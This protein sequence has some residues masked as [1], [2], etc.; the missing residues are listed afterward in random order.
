MDTKNTPVINLDGREDIGPETSSNEV[1]V[2]SDSAKRLAEG[3]AIT[4]K[5]NEIFASSWKS[6]EANA[7]KLLRCQGCMRKFKNKMLIGKHWKA[8]NGKC[9]KD[10]GFELVSDIEIRPDDV[11]TPEEREKADFLLKANK[12]A[13]EAA[14]QANAIRNVNIDRSIKAEDLM[15][16]PMIT[17]DRI[18][19]NAPTDELKRFVQMR[20]DRMTSSRL[21]YADKELERRGVK[22]VASS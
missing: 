9:N 8:K 1:S 6:R 12:A 19:K 16:V 10:M 20:F 11:S 7:P 15:K 18:L 22:T 2:S 21:H 3:L 4:E 14:A 13:Q 17:L 5:R